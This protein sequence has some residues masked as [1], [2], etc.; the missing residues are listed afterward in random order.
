MSNTT[1]TFLRKEECEK[2]EDHK[3]NAKHKSVYDDG[4]TY[5]F[6][7]N[8]RT[9]PTSFT[10]Y[11]EE[12]IKENIAN[13]KDFV[14]DYRDITT[15]KLTRKTCEL[16][17]IKS[18]NIFNQEAQ[19]YEYTRGKKIRILPKEFT[20]LE[21]SAKECSMFGL[22]KAKDYT[23]CLIIT[24]GELDAASC[25]E[26]G[27][28]AC[29]LHSGASSARQCIQFD[30]DTLLKFKEIWIGF[31]KDEAG[32]DALKVALEELPLE[33][34]RL[35]D[36]EAHKDANEALISGD[37]SHILTHS[38]T[39]WRPDG[40]VFG[41]ELDWE[42]IWKP[43]PEGLAFPWKGLNEMVRG[44][45]KGR[46][47]LW[48]GG[49]SIGKSSVLRELSYFL[50]TEYPA[51]KIAH[52]FLE[53]DYEAG[54]L[55]YLALHESV[56][57]GNLL[58]DKDLIAKERRI[59]VQK[60]LNKNTMF[61]NEQYELGSEELLK[62]LEWLAVV[63][64]YDIIV[65]DHISMVA[66]AS[67][68]KESERICINKLMLKLRSLVRRT[69]LTVH[70]AC[71]LSNPDQGLDWEDGREVRQK[72]FHGSSAL[73]KVPDVMIGVERNM[74]D[75]FACDQLTLRVIKNRW[76]SRTGI[77][78][79]LIYFNKSGRLLRRD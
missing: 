27:Y 48:G 10:G 13:T 79:T 52:L 38:V 34:L 29:S 58:E 5:C 74:R 55:T 16:L 7:C 65:L 17:G 44:Q 9:P 73:R 4:H 61:T 35:I 25:W 21:G 53:E 41:D 36:W 70:A 18:G 8:T 14:G 28:Q 68:S 66:E 6:R 63:K 77:S 30:K 40:I 12:P 3:W 33:K 51:L 11:Y 42:E 60:L 54:P 23:S 75:P 15:R 49:A 47:Y 26:L 57:L 56:P 20:W 62:Q 64:K 31:D 71:H 43:R 19:L 69:G 59:E 45:H 76:F 37:L 50:R 39:E 72:D 67:D 24:E 32:A 2:C 22:D 78:D 46:L 1:S